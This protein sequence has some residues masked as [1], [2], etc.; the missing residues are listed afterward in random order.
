MKNKNA[1]L[2]SLKIERNS[3]NNNAGES[4]IKKIIVPVVII[5][6]VIFAVYFGWNSLI[7]TGIEVNLVTA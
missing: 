6:V 5:V 1:D 3:G 7:S 2:S 4:N